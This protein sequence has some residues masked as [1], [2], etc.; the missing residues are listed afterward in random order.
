ML[1]FS[2]LQIV[3]IVTGL[4]ITVAETYVMALRITDYISCNTYY[5]L[6]IVGT[7]VMALSY[8][9]QYFNKY[10]GSLDFRL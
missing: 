4:Q 3:I 9:L 7:F 8:R 10:Y 5:A 1:N 6:R 2:G